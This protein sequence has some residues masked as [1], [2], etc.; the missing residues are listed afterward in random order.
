METGLRGKLAPPGRLREAAVVPSP[1]L[2]LR[3]SPSPPSRPVERPGGQ[4]APR[5]NGGGRGLL[6][7]ELGAG[8]RGGK[9]EREGERRCRAGCQLVACCPAGSLRVPFPAPRFVFSAGGEGGA[10]RRLGRWAPPGPRG[11][12]GNGTGHRR[13]SGPVPSL[14]RLPLPTPARELV[15]FLPSSD[16]FFPQN[17]GG[18]A[19]RRVWWGFGVVFLEPVRAPGAVGGRGS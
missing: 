3:F 8:V 18:A 7:V 14:L 5:E 4:L 2:P 12:G 11:E 1:G 16:F 9:S 19:R 17:V 15:W 13:R 6:P 10:A